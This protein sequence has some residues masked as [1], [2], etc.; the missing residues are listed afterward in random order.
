MT[1]QPAIERLYH[2]PQGLYTFQIEGVV[3]AFSRQ[4]N[5]CVWDTGTGKTHLA[6]ATAAMLFEDGLV[7][8]VLIVAEKNKIESD[9]WP[10]DFAKFTDL[11]AA[12]YHGAIAKRIKMREALPQVIIS[13][14][15]TIKNDCA[16]KVEVEG[17]KTKKLEAGPLIQVLAGK[18]V[19]VVYDEMTK[20]GNRKSDNHKA[21]NL[22]V[23][24]LRREGWCKVL[25][26]TAT[27]IERNPENYYNLGRI[28]MPDY[29]GTVAN[30]EKSYIAAWDIFGNPS[31]FKNLTAE[32]MTDPNV[33][34]LADVMRPILMRKRKTDP[35]VIDQFPSTVEEFTYVNLGLRQQEFYDTVVET[36]ED[37]DEWTQRKL[38]VTLRQI[39]GHPLALLGSEAEVAKTIVDQVGIKGLAALGS[40]KTDRLV[41]YLD[42][43]VNGQGAQVVVFAFFGPSMIPLLRDAIED[44]GISVAINHGQMSDRDRTE[45][46]EAFRAGRR[47]VFLTSDAGARG[48]NLPESSYAVE[49]ELSLTH[50]NRVQRLNR[51]HRIDSQH[52]SVTFQS[53]IARGTV[54]EGIAQMVLRRNDWTDK[55]LDD[56]D[57]G[58]EFVTAEMRRRLLAVAR[59]AR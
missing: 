47:S 35:D 28:F 45:S 15:E 6:M 11:D 46:K 26:L 9:E 17:R 34:P 59:G 51:I 3:L 44:A 53:F 29:I 5:L 31:R 42:P 57:P 16:R 41:E 40:A 50:A 14:Y 32:A 55:L 1:T 48:I 56:D 27:P 52:P 18:R 8:H 33:V 13:T 21:H 10:G 12:V 19:M 36:F 7:D 58:D 25:G 43:L 24:T 2:S 22:M 20:L 38:F 30:F 54:E 23:Q 49:Y 37:A 4:D 39:A